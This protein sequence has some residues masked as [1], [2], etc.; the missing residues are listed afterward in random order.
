MLF[1]EVPLSEAEGAILAHTLHLENAVMKKGTA[2][3]AA[4]IAVLRAAGFAS[5]AVARLDE[6]DVGENEAAAAVAA[7][8]TGPS[9]FAAAPVNGRVNLF[10]AEA[11]V[12]QVDAARI[13][14]ANGIDEAIT[15]ATLAPFARVAA[16]QMLATVKIIPY[17]APRAGVEAVVAALQGEEPVLAVASF[18]PLRVALVQTTAPRLKLSVLEKTARI[19]AERCAGLGLHFLGETRCAHDAAALQAA[20]ERVCAAERPDVLLIA[21]ASAIADRNDVAPRALTA[22]GGR[23]LHLGMPVEPGNL[24]ML[25]ARGEATVIGLPG[26]AR[27]P[28]LNG[29]DW[30]LER[31]AARLPVDAAALARMSVGGLLTE[32]TYS[33]RAVARAD[34]GP[35]ESEAAPRPRIVALVL[36]AGMARRMG[37]NKLTSPMAGVPMVRRVVETALAS[38]CEEVVVVTGHE[39]DAVREALAGLAVRFVHADSYAQGLGASLAAGA[40][41]VPEACDAFVVMLGDMPLVRP[42]IV[43]ALIARFAAGEGADILVPTFAD[44]QGNPVLF[45][46]RFAEALAHLGGDRG[47]RSVIEANRAVVANVPVDDESVL[48]DA[49][50]PER[51]AALA[52]RLRS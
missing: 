29:L 15:V 51:F 37:S 30:V 8:I 14:Q 38:P 27:S 46:R 35:P 1:A 23:V 32:F 48:L 18:S 39:A 31:L 2:L 47:A 3:D 22:S 52:E 4:A 42:A 26:C 16:K 9:M 13:V 20:I 12:F 49:D 43:E 41:A 11:G 40:A 50:T 36:A 28:K 21:G 19:T 10:A 44:K 34:Y 6:G 33:P 24:L 5:I 17:A 7:A 45:A 25:G